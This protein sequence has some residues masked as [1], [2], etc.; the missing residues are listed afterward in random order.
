MFRINNSRNIPTEDAL[1]RQF[2]NFQQ[3]SVQTAPVAPK[4]IPPPM[5]SPVHPPREITITPVVSQ[6]PQPSVQLPSS[7]YQIQN[8]ME[9]FIQ[10]ILEHPQYQELFKGPQGPPGDF[11]PQ[12]PQGEQGPQGP[13][14]EEGAEGYEGPEGPPGPPGPPGPVGPSG[15]IDMSNGLDLLGHSITNLS[16]PINDS[17]AVTKKYVDDLFERLDAFLRTQQA[18]TASI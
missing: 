17:D 15:E 7:N 2:G 6:Q 13:P 4:Y 14:G 9:A 16:E 3:S 11:G 10:L 1:K 5:P 12:G 8:D 18:S